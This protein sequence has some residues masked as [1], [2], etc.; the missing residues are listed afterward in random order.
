MG[1]RIHFAQGS[2]LMILY[3]IRR[4]TNLITCH[5]NLR[6]LATVSQVTFST[7]RETWVS[8][9]RP[10][11]T[12]FFAAPVSFFLSCGGRGTSLTDP[13]IFPIALEITVKKPRFCG[14]WGV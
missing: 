12:F 7:P 14:R 1:S 4:Q 10:F 5:M 6:P 2:F 11:P 8:R 9:G 13:S 3:F